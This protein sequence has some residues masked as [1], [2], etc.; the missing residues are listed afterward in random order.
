[1]LVDRCYAPVSC[2]D[3]SKTFRSPAEFKSVCPIFTPPISSLNGI[4]PSRGHTSCISE[5]EKYEKSVYK[6]P[7][8]VRSMLFLST[9]HFHLHI[10]LRDSQETKE[11][12]IKTLQPPPQSPSPTN[13]T[14][15]DSNNAAEAAGPMPVHPKQARTKSPL[16]QMHAHSPPL[17]NLHP[18]QALLV[19]LPH[20]QRRS[21]RYLF[22]PSPSSARPSGSK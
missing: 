20:P 21:P 1:M 2:I 12:T 11:R 19:T 22:Q 14:C 16:A 8:T 9:T 3:C 5:A 7:K 4:S 6:G 15:A 10:R 17:P 18:H 13:K